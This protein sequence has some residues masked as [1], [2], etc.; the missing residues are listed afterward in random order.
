M[1]L[2]HIFHLSDLHIRNGD[3]MY[4]RYEEY[5]EVFKETI[6]SIKNNIES[7]NLSLNDFIIVITGDIFHNKNVIGNYDIHKYDEHNDVEHKH[8]SFNTS[9]NF[10]VNSCFVIESISSDVNDI[11]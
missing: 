8:V 6:T 11:P 10:I 4:S 2:T 1:V 9:F 7:L 5:K 3:N